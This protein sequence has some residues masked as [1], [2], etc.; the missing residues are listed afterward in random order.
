MN[1]RSHTVR[2]AVGACCALALGACSSGT[3]TTTTSF[4]GQPA[5]AMFSN[6][7]IGDIVMTASSG[8]VQQGQLAL[9]RSTSQAVR[10]FAQRMIVDHSNAM[11]QTATLLGN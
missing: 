6:A 10:D 9:S 3:S 2:L 1:R 8:E 7:D 5:G 11:Q 4:T